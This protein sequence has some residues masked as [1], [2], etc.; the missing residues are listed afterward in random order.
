MQTIQFKEEEKSI[1]LMEKGYA[2]FPLLSP[3]QIAQLTKTFYEFHKQEPQGFYAT[4]HIEDK[5]LRKTLSDQISTVIASET[6]RL[7][8][9][10]EILGGAYIAKAS[11]DKGI[12]PLHQDWN[13]VDEKMARSYNLWIPLVDVSP[14]NGTMKILPKS[15]IKQEN[16][17][18][19]GIPSLFQNI[20]EVVDEYMLSLNMKAGEALLYDHA[21]WHSSPKNNT[22]KLRLCIVLGVVP[23]STPLKYYAPRE[24]QIAEF[25]SYSDFFF[26]HDNDKGA[27]HLEFHQYV[28]H[29]NEPISTDDF[30]TRYLGISA[31]AKPKKKKWFNLFSRKQK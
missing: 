26:E 20:T 13:I 8:H 2:T 11:G 16:Y 15:H 28:T 22:Q 12:L 3:E 4:T 18:G 21:L 19:P 24:N 29:D 7:F 5:A 6:P 27:D 30:L 9:N 10:M 31:S 1:A 14:E 25:N 17:R 23:T